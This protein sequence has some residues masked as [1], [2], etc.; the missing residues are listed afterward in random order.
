M[1]SIFG[2]KDKL[3]RQAQL[4]LAQNKFQ[5]AEVLLL[6]YIEKSSDNFGQLYLALS[7]HQQNRTDEA[8]GL[9]QD[10]IKKSPKDIEVFHYY[11]ALLQ[12]DKNNF[13]KCNSELAKIK[14]T[15]HFHVALKSIAELF[16]DFTGNSKNYSQAFAIFKNCGTVSTDI[17]ARILFK[18]ESYLPANLTKRAHTSS[19]PSHWHPLLLA[20]QRII[21]KNN[22]LQE[23]LKLAIQNAEASEYSKALELLESCFSLELN[24]IEVEK[25]RLQISE[26]LLTKQKDSLAQVG[27]KE[28]AWAFFYTQQFQKGVEFCEPYLQSKNSLDSNAT[29][30]DILDVAGYLQFCL[31]NFAKA[32]SILQ[33]KIQ[34]DPKDSEQATYYYG[35]CLQHLRKPF[36]ALN[37][38]K[39][40][41][42]NSL[43]GYITQINCA[44]KT[45]DPDLKIS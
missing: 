3:L 35:A 24:Y 1:N 43:D 40:F 15:N 5:E 9:L 8:L 18:L 25:V 36:E 12:F 6:K 7:I 34:L 44:M 20:K 19:L 31:G 21:D 45:I 16:N 26:I 37:A 28:I 27:A 33:T 30:L 2:E 11:R 42:N 14:N 10:I 23:L 41:I 13:G 4:H 39:N 17:Q 29:Y 32:E 22:R 38:Y